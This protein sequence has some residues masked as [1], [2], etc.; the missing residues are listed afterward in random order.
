MVTDSFFDKQTGLTAAKIKIFKEYIQGYLPKLLT[1]FEECIIADLFCGAGK[2]GEEDGSPLVLIDRSN[3]ILTSPHLKKAKIN[4]V[5]N[6]QDNANIEN[7]NNEISNVEINDNINIEQITNCKFD[8]LLPELLE[9]LK[10]NRL[11]KFFFLDPY[12]YSNIK[13]EN[14]KEIMNLQHT[15]V[16]LFIPI[17]HSY[18]FASDTTMPEYHKTR[19]FVEKFTTKGVTDYSGIDDFME[20]VK[21]KILADLELDYVRP[22]LLDDGGKK[23]SLFLLTKHQAG[24]LLMNK[25]AIKMTDD[26]STVKIKAQNQKSLFGVEE[27]TK[28]DLFTQRII[29][30]LENQKNMSNGEIIEYTIRE[31]YT[32]KYVYKIMVELF[33]KS[34]IKVYDSDGKEVIS[35]KQWNI[36]E[37]ITKEIY[38]KWED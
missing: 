21:Q 16:L 35:K 37:K 26:G 17:F 36:A 2:N 38:F 13:M 12:T 7:L 22:V 6:D 10:D 9:E 27:S 33:D 31:G 8:S 11:P 5:F 23:N 18:R 32:P 28:F 24:I 15:E 19:I 29:K 25:I 34:K 20:S 3:Y 1:T 14:L 4:I 30:L